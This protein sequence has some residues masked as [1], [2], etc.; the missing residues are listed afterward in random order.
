M[1]IKGT[2]QQVARGKYLAYHVSACID[3]HSTR[4]WSKFSGPIKAGTIGKGGETFDQRMGL[5][6]KFISR[7]ITPYNLHD[8][9]DG[10]I[11]RAIT[12]GVTKDGHPLFSVMPYQ[13]YGKMDPRDF[14]A[15]IAYIRTLKPI[16][17]DPPASEANFPM[18][19]ILQTIPVKKT[20]AGIIG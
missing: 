14:K 8:W 7:N 15:I 20:V 1:T 2:A 6:G 5:P 3:C 13:S 9:T 16:T 11:Y 19:L 18:N 4:N 12:T 17:Y 10:D